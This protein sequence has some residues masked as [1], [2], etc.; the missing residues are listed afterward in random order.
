MEMAERGKE[1]GPD[2]ANE[3]FGER[4]DYNGFGAG[5]VF[6]LVSVAVIALVLTILSNLG[7]LARMGLG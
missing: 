2:F 1:E 5:V 3:V 4:G 7:V 6:V